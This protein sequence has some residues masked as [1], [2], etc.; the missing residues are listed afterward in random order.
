MILC[1][2]AFNGYLDVLKLWRVRGQHIG[3]ENL[4]IGRLCFWA[5]MGGQLATL[6]SYYIIC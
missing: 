1:V 2:A 6:L 3:P 5:A 4:W